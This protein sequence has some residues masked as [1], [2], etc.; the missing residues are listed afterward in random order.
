MK[1]MK[2][3][4]AVLT[5]IV[6]I[7]G[8]V[9]GVTLLKEPAGHDS[10]GG[11]VSFTPELHHV[12]ENRYGG[13]FY[14]DI[15]GA[16]RE[17]LNGTNEIQKGLASAVQ[18]Q[19]KMR[20]EVENNTDAVDDLNATVRK[21]GGAIVIA[22]SAAILLYGLHN[23]ADASSGQNILE[24]VQENSREITALRHELPKE[25]PKQTDAPGQNEGVAVMPVSSGDGKITCPLCGTV[26]HEARTS[27]FHCGAVFTKND[28]ETE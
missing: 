27:C 28:R 19:N 20:S 26:Q 18:A 8:I 7:A 23:I 11:N 16:A 10:H 15:Y 14:T 3:V 24:A 25:S 22:V 4:I 12:D 21:T 2:K 6:G 13:D 5:I 17:I 9:F 1:T